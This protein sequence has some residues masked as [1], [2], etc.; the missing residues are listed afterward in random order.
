M[1]PDIAGSNTPTVLGVAF[2][3]IAAVSWRRQHGE[4]ARH[5]MVAR[6][7][8]GDHCRVAVPVVARDVGNVVS[9]SRQRR[10]RDVLYV[11]RVVGWLRLDV[12]P[13]KPLR[14]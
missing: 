13:R 3:V 6:V 10:R 2:A 9:G 11:D 5:A 8:R 4:P 7:E 12:C 1:Q 14:C